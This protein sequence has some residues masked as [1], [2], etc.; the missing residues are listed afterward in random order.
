MNRRKFLGVSLLSAIAPSVLVPEEKKETYKTPSQERM[1]ITN[2]GNII[3]HPTI[4]DN[5]SKLK[6]DNK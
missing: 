3:L 4:T 6:I 5:G 1:R 2:S